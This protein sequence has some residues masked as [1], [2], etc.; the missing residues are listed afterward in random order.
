MTSKVQTL[1]TDYF[2][3]T[4]T[5]T[6]TDI[7]EHFQYNYIVSGYP[8]STCIFYNDY[9]EYVRERYENKEEPLPFDEVDEYM[10]EICNIETINDE[11]CP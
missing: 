2:T 7:L 6:E 11:Y 5:M 10:T 8:V 4:S 9:C 1:I 3:E